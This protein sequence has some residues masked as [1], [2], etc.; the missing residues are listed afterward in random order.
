MQERVKIFRALPSIVTHLQDKMN[1]QRKEE[2]EKVA[3]YTANYC[4]WRRVLKKQQ[5]QIEEQEVKRY[6]QQAFTEFLRLSDKAGSDGP[7]YR[8][9]YS[10]QASSKRSFYCPVKHAK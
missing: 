3:E 6:G 1:T 7:R 4:E 10:N 8:Q 9:L 5:K 2:K